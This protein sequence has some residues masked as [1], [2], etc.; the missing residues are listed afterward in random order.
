[1]Y[2]ALGNHDDANTTRS[3]A[4]N[5]GYFSFPS[6]TKWRSFNYGNIHVANLALFDTAGYKATPTP[7]PQYTWISND[8][9]SA[10]QSSTTDWIFVTMHFLPWSIGSHGYN[11]AADLRTYLHPLF[12]DSAP[13]PEPVT[14]AFG[15]HNHLYCRYAPVDGVT[16][17]TSGLA[18]GT[19]NATAPTPWPGATPATVRQNI[20]ELCIVDVEEN[21]VSVRAVDVTG[22]RLDYVTFGKTS[23]LPPFAD[24]GSNVT[25]IAGSPITL[26]GSASADPDGGGLTYSW[27]QVMWPPTVPTVSLSGENTAQPSFT[28]TLCGDYL[29][30]L[31]V[32]D[33]TDWS[34]P[35]FC[36]ATVAEATLTFNSE[37]DTYIDSNNPTT[38]YGS[39]TW[40]NV[41]SKYHTY[42]RFNVT[43]VPAEVIRATLRLYGL[44]GAYPCNIST[45]S[46][47]TW[48]ESSP[49]WNNPLPEDGS[50]LGAIPAQ[51]TPQ[52]YESDVTDA[53]HGNGAVTFVIL[54]P[55]LS[56]A[57]FRSNNHATITTRPQLVVAYGATIK[58][59]DSDSDGMTDYEEIYW[60]GDEHYN[61]YPAGGD[62]NMESGDTDGDGVP[63]VLEIGC[64]G[65]PLTPGL[66][67]NT[68]RINFQPVD[69]ARPTGYARDRG[70]GYSSAR[71]YGWR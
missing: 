8:L 28:T 48:A 58:T 24:A 40:L 49:T 54:E 15:G 51:P 5:Y 38:N 36:V 57:A 59:R 1:M 53:V 9:A 19:A 60:D 69:S 12:R 3:N 50:I 14:C 46:D 42:L 34:A 68:I 30:M 32:F 27:S 35:D 23:N 56:T 71:S 13:T 61:P 25:G 70:A 31:R 55:N 47:T 18:G 41:G 63:D 10:R 52:W 62:L 64:G 37:A 33:G 66:P 17:I 43:G 65:D 45:S 26:D 44:S 67:L 21:A 7:S 11:E 29:F 22:K 4:F 16:Y 20:Q 2:V 6:G 39:A